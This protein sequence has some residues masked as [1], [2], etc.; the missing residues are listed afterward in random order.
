MSAPGGGYDAVVIV[1]FG[2]P[3]GPD[4]VEPFLDNVLRG[5]P[6]PAERRAAVAAHYHHFGGRSPING[7]NR[8]LV[9]ALGAELT[10]AAGGPDL[11]VSLPAYLPVYW[12]NRNWHPFLTDAVRQMA[13][14]GV[15]RALAF[16]T[17][18]YASYSGCHQYLEDI[19][20]ARAAVGPE[21]PEIDKLRV[22]YNHPGFVR[23]NVDALQAARA[24]AGVGS[25]PVRVAFTA[26]SIP[27]S[28][29]ATSDYQRQLTETARLVMGQF[30]PAGVVPWSLVF[31]SRS[32]PPAVAWLEPDILDHLRTLAANGGAPV[33]VAPI[34]FV[35]D[36]MEVVYDLDVEAAQLASQ[37][38][39]TMA[40]AATAGVHPA[41]VTMIRQLVEERMDPA[42]PKLALGADGP[43]HDVC[44]ADCCP[45]PL[46]QRA[47]HP[48]RQ[49]APLL[50]STPAGG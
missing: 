45:A 27:V 23:A 18:A 24:S 39:L 42:V 6:V 3:E 38:G 2:G 1:S 36:H 7:H 32:G 26:H 46:R 19:A 34:G 10:L 44:R 13:E 35:A 25:S 16:V 28:M 49:A 20:R 22:F 48:P 11:P 21:A 12:G 40:R 47:P 41:F 17:S 14:D 29:A 15:R 50:P 9:A 43:Y 31:Q 33:I 30:D 4:D 37:L 5:R 8:A